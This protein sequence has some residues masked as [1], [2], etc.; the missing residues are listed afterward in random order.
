MKRMDEIK[1]PP[2]IP[3]GPEIPKD[4][5]LPRPKVYNRPAGTIYGYALPKEAGMDGKVL[6]NAGLSEHVAVL[7]MSG[8]HTDR[9]L[10]ESEPVMAGIKLP[11]TKPY[12]TIAAFDFAALVDAV[13][14]WI[15]LALEKSAA[16]SSPQDAEMV[17]MHAKT[18][19]QI[20][21]CY[22]GTVSATSKEGKATVTRT[23]SEF[24]D[25]D[26]LDE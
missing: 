22:R 18:A 25:V 14:P 6:P 3:G 8:R 17:Q 20:L 5:K 12:G 11:L 19:L 9:L 26:E 7:S 13:T 4:F 21:K 10:S 23:R 1:G 24:R 16:Q 15:N 2:G